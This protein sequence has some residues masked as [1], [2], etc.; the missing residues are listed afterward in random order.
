MP[1]D[2]YLF[3]DLPEAYVWT[4]G[5]DLLRD[6]GIMYAEKLKQD[7]VKVTQVNKPHAMHG[8]YTFKVPSSS[9]Y[10]KEVAQFIKERLHA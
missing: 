9:V 2:I 5:Y 1:Y 10:R 4:T 3:A 6:D 8:A 7:G